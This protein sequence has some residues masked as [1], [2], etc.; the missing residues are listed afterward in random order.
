VTSS[1]ASL[2]FDDFV[3]DAGNG[4]KGTKRRS[5]YVNSLVRGITALLVFK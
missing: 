3:G 2:A 5:I 1:S 4:E